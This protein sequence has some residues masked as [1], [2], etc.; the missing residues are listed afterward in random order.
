[1]GNSLLTPHPLFCPY[2]PPF[3]PPSFLLLLV[4][5]LNLTYHKVLIYNPIV[6]D[7]TSPSSSFFLPFS[8]Y[9]TPF[10]LPIQPPLLFFYFL[11]TFSTPPLLISTYMSSTTSYFIFP[12]FILMYIF[13][14]KKFEFFIAVP[15]FIVFISSYLGI[16]FSCFFVYLSHSYILLFIFILS[17]FSIFIHIP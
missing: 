6:P 11:T 12:F 5:N 16:Q 13:K 4:H 9:L 7:L 10:F 15:F 14:K 8:F 1:M 2:Y 3:T 17:T